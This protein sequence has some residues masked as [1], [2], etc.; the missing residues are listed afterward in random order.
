VRYVADTI[1][2]S[3]GFRVGLVHLKLPPRMLEWGGSEDPVAEDHESVQRAR[4]Y[5]AKEQEETEKGETL[6][7]RIRGSLADKGIEAAALS[8]QFEE[9]LEPKAI[10]H[11]L[12]KVAKE[13]DY[14]TVVV[15]RHAFSGLKRLFQHHV[16][17]EL[18]RSGHGLSIWVAE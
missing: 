17:E 12:I 5:R 15:G 14:D 8:V 4:A 13:N 11:K 16:G 3:P 1:A 2:G 6:L 7:Q 18:V 10:A 9:P